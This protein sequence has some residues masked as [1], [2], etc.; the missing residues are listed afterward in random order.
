MTLYLQLTIQELHW[1]ADIEYVQA[2]LADRLYAPGGVI[3]QQIYVTQPIQSPKIYQ[4]NGDIVLQTIG[5][6][7]IILSAAT[8]LQLHGSQVVIDSTSILNPLIYLAD[9]TRIDGPL[10]AQRI[11][12]NAPE[13]YTG[14]IL[15]VDS[16]FTVNNTGATL[17]G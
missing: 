2:E 14:N 13:S 6:G 17:V 11:T 1:W 10:T 15:N 16:V 7:N 5:S 9:E 12:L 4:E 3:T 8:G